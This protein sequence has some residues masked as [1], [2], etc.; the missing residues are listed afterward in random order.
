LTNKRIFMFDYQAL[1]QIVTTGNVTYRERGV[2]YVF[3]CPRCNGHEKLFIRKTDGRFVCWVCKEISNFRGKAEYALKEI[4]RKPLSYFQK[5]L[6]GYELPET[7]DYLELDLEDKFDDNPENFWAEPIQSAPGVIWPPDF[8]DYRSPGFMPATTYL[9]SRGISL[10]L[11]AK[12][13]IR[14]AAW[15][16]RVAFPI[17]VNS[18]LLGWQSR[19]IVNT[20]T[21]NPGPGTITQ[22]PK[23]ITSPSLKNRGGQFLMFQDNLLGAKH[24]V[25]TEGPV[26]AL[27]CELC[28]GNVASMGKGVTGTQLAVIKSYGVRRLYIGLDPDAGSDI[29]RISAD[30]DFEC[31]LLQ[32]PEGKEDLGDCTE[33]EVYA[34]MQKAPPIPRGALVLSIGEL[35]GF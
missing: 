15:Q 7:M 25:L 12:Y 14:Y 35:L 22:I 9:A 4:Y 2:S 20:K 28:G 23:I 26:S 18:V 33:S 19:L 27:K 31:F 6:Y 30:P 1:R 3:D 29:A 13:D 21:W 32:P 34:Q 11:I 5:I 24:C 17:K 10:P 8:L 16:R